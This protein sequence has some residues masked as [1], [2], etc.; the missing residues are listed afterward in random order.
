MTYAEFITMYRGYV[1]RQTNKT[2][3]MIYTAWHT[4]LFERQQKL[5]ELNSIL[6]DEKKNPDKQR[7]QTP[8][9][10]LTIC[11]MWN[12]ALGGAEVES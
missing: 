11:R 8:D 3:E 2:N 5:P 12:A 10:M 9:E 6:I 1:R 7:E 4:A